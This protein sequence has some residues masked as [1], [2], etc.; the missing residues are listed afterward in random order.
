MTSQRHWEG[1]HR[2]AQDKA[3]TGVQRR[4]QAALIPLPQPAHLTTEGDVTEGDVVTS[5]GARWR[6]RGWCGGVT[7]GEAVTS[8][9]AGSAGCDIPSPLPAWS[10]SLPPSSGSHLTQVAS[11]THTYPLSLTLPAVS[12]GPQRWIT[13]LQF[14]SWIP[15]TVL[16]NP[17]G[18]LF[19]SWHGL[20][21]LS[22]RFVNVHLLPYSC[23][24]PWSLVLRGC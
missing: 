21:P 7:E 12:S 6:H 24:S 19:P 9:G 20:P 15:W 16:H 10:A 22:W 14:W 17:R 8:E 18:T 4:A 2:C 3:L 5:P 23:L 11:A 1:S 13:L